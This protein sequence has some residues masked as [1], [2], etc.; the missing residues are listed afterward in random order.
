M[1]KIAVIMIGASGSGK[2]S[3][4][5]ALATMDVG[6]HKVV[7][8]TTRDI[9]LEDGEKDGET[10]HYVSIEEFKNIPMVEE[11]NFGGNFYGVAEKDFETDKDILVVVEPHGA[12]QILEY[13][14]D[15][16][17]PIVIYMDIPKET[18]IENMRKRGDSEE[19]IQK[20]LNI[21]DIE[22]RFR[23]SGIIADKTVK[24]LNPSLH[25]DVYEFIQITKKNIS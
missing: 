5:K 3:L 16:Y 15:E 8:Y 9:R 22:E 6:F 21:D 24:K 18:R 10:Y 20:R 7:S 25:L 23:S 12:E 13:I 2:S 17:H 14:G 19:K 4:E 1:K 11:V